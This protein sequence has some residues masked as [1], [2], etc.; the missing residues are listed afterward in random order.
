M[1]KDEVLTMALDALIVDRAF[2]EDDTPDEIWDMNYNVIVVIKQALE[3][4][5]QERNFCSRCGK[6]LGSN[7]WDVHTCTPP[8]GKE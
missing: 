6:R 5:E 8:R 1:T 7:D 3:Q 4:S 2:L